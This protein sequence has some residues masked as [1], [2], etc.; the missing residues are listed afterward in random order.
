MHYTCI[1]RLRLRYIEFL[2]EQ[3]TKNDRNH[4]LLETVNS[5]DN[6]LMLMTAKINRLNVLKAQ[7]EDYHR[8]MYAIHSLPENTIDGIDRMK[9]ENRNLKRNI[10]VKRLSP[11]VKDRPS[12]QMVW[13][14]HKTDQNLIDGIKN[15]NYNDEKH[16]TQLK[17]LNQQ[18][19]DNQNSLQTRQ[20]TQENG[21]RS[22]SFQNSPVQHL[23]YKLPYCQI[24][25]D[26]Y[27][28]RPLSNLPL[29]SLSGQNLSYLA[30]SPIKRMET[31]QVAPSRCKL[32][33]VFQN[34]SRSEI[35]RDYVKPTVTMHSLRLENNKILNDTRLRLN[36][37]DE[38]NYRSTPVIIEQNAPSISFTN[39]IFNLPTRSFKSYLSSSLKNIARPRKSVSNSSMRSVMTSKDLDTDVLS[40]NEE[41]QENESRTTTILENEL[42]KY[43]AKLDKLHR[44]HDIQSSKEVD[45]EQSTNISALNE[46]LLNNDRQLYTENQSNESFPKDI[47]KVFALADDLASRT[48]D[49]NDVNDFEEECGNKIENLRSTQITSNNIPVSERNVLYSNTDEGHETSVA[50]DKINIDTA[51]HEPKLGSHEDIEKSEKRNFNSINNMHAPM[52]Q[53]QPLKLQE[54]ENVDSIDLPNDQFMKQNDN[55]LHDEENYKEHDTYVSKKPQND[56]YFSDI[57]EELKPQNLDSA[58][59][60]EDEIELTEKAEDKFGESN[61]IINDSEFN[62][63]NVTD[64]ETINEIKLG[65]S[66][67]EK[68]DSK[69]ETNLGNTNDQLYL[70]NNDYSEL[71]K[72]TVDNCENELNEVSILP[73]KKLEYEDYYK[74][75]ENITENQELGNYEYAEQKE[76]DNVQ[77]EEC[78]DTNQISDINQ[79]NTEEMIMQDKDYNEDSNQDQNYMHDFETQQFNSNEEYNY[80]QNPSYENN[81]DLNYDQNVSPDGNQQQEYTEYIQES[82]EQSEPENQYEQVSNVQNEENLNQ[83]YPS[84]EQSNADQAAD[85]G[86]IETDDQSV[87]YMGNDNFNQSE[88]MQE[89]EDK[90]VCKYEQS[91]QEESNQKVEVSETFNMPQNKNVK[92]VAE[93]E[94]N[95]KKDVIK[96]L[97]DSDTD[98]TIE[99]NVSNAE[100]DFDFN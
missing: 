74:N 29:N 24:D 5:V 40:E 8:Q 22:P 97:L 87:E 18:I 64:V 28:S 86:A 10:T 73:D 12:S 42:D 71:E 50:K 9:S 69:Q 25:S 77:E 3:R 53:E 85:K 26:L 79:N 75:N 63:E 37:V 2:E 14:D 6:S 36:N 49:L 7:Y 96:S 58:H 21:I 47:E 93:N 43:I 44:D 46:T 66:Q 56:Q 30:K 31:I 59:K 84:Y 15:K 4:K 80:D 39:P 95:Q 57:A 83:Q 1:S 19:S 91:Q 62:Q 88:I 13:L 16:G 17:P 98:S 78:Y 34:Q 33:D 68:Q 82:N 94:S 27:V 81:Q 38:V 92:P 55:N 72:D 52:Q 11:E 60:Q 61:I 23:Q 20:I 48:I 90:E 76:F 51:L 41:V 67:L 99:R 70:A 89:D 35:S 45:E 100:S 32:L 54:D 65:E